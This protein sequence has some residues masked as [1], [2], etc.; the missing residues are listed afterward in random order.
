MLAEFVTDQNIESVLLEELV[1]SLD[2][3]R[4]GCDSNS[5]VPS[6]PRSVTLTRSVAHVMID[7]CDSL[8][9]FT[10]QRLEQDSHG[11]TLDLAKIGKYLI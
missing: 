9:Y 3:D 1:E 10:S 7:L 8:T 11:V 4:P 2:A 6:H 5:P